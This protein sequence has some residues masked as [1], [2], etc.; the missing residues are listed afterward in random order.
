MLSPHNSSLKAPQ[1]YDTT[2]RD[3]AQT[4]GVN[5]SMD[6]KLS[7]IHIL[8]ELGIDYIE[9][10]WPGSNPK[11]QEFF[12]RLLSIDSGKTQFVAF[13]A[14][15][16]PQLRVTEDPQ[17]K[18]LLAAQTPVVTLVAKTWDYHVTEVLNTDLKNNLAMIKDSVAFCKDSG[19]QVILDCE[20]FFDGYQNNAHYA[21]DCLAAALEAGADNISLCDT[22]GGQMPE[23]ISEVVH[24]MRL[25]FPSISLGIHCHNDCELA[26]ANSLAAWRSGVELIQGTMN[27]VGERCGNANLTSLLPTLQLKYQVQCLEEE[28]LS[29]L[30][31][32]AQTLSNIFNLPLSAY[33]PY[34]GRSA[35][36]HKGGIHV[37]AVEKAPDTYEHVNPNLVGNHREILISELSGRSNV[38][39]Q[40]QK[41]ETQHPLNDETISEVLNAVKRLEM[42]G[43]D[44]EESDGTFELLVH[45]ATEQYEPAFQLLEVNS[46]FHHHLGHSLCQGMVKLRIHGQQV[47]TIAEAEGPIEA[48]DKAFRLALSPHFKAIEIIKLI[49]YKVRIIDPVKAAA[50]TTRVW[51]QATDGEKTWS[52]VGC[53]QNIITASSHA[54]NDCFELFLA[55]ISTKRIQD[56]DKAA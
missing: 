7:V 41:L 2:L 55:R 32:A 45:K 18:S 11:D 9:A 36:A 56:D 34:V 37:S 28:K 52:T 26:V 21:H 40:M 24:T 43:L 3:G 25:L 6:D 50:A 35:F 31:L 12:K 13:G 38:R 49:D 53:S 10:G 23:A 47:H 16:R 29:Q 48:I 51:I 22:N 14:T 27:G 42:E 19:K 15:R 4:Q 20:H 44:L 17:L 30:T 39:V 54:L 1:I 8:C 5:L 33:T 46:H